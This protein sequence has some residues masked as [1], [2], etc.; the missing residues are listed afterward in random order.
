MPDSHVNAAT[1]LATL[2]PLPGIFV[3]DTGGI[4]GLGA[5]LLAGGG[6]L[7]GLY[8]PTA[9]RVEVV[10]KSDRWQQ[11][12]HELKLCSGYFGLPNL[13]L[14][15]VPDA[16][17]GDEYKFFVQ[18]GV[19]Q[20]E[21]WVE[22]PYA[23]ELG[24][25]FEDNNC[26]VVDPTGFHWTDAG[27]R[28]PDRADLILYELSV[29][30]FTEGD[31]DIQEDRRGKFAG[32]AERVEEGYFERLGVTALS[33][34]PLAEFPDPQGPGTLG[35]SPSLYCTVERD[36]GTPDD[37]R[38][39]V[40]TAHGHGLAVILDQV[41]N[42][43]SND[44]N[45]LWQL[46]L[47][48]PDEE[49][50]DGE[51]GLYFNG[52]TPWGNRIA[53][54]RED[55]Q[56]LLIDA[57]KLLIA[58]YHVDGFRFDATHTDYM[59]HGFLGRL[60]RELTAF[61]PEVILIA[62][63]LPN[64]SDLNRSGFDGFAQW[65]DPYHDKMKALLREGTYQEFN[66]YDTDRLADIFYFSR[67]IYAA[68]TNNVVN[69]TE[70]HD[71]TSVP[72]EVG[73][74][75]AL[76]HPAA[77]D[78][79]GRLGLFATMVALGQPMIYMGHEF[80]VERDRNI[81]SFAWPTDGPS[82]NGF[83]RWA[84]RLIP[85]R[86]RYPALRISGSDPAG[87]GRF[88][89]IL[90]PWMDQRHGGGKKV[91]GWR[92]RPTANAFDTM[93]VLLSFENHPVTVDLELGLAGTWVKLADVESANDVPPEGTNSAGDPTALHSSDGRFGGFELPGSSGF[94]YK[95]EE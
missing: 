23:R 71:E 6:V 1:F 74:N 3:P 95:W 38:N 58:E 52:T 80:N 45:P 24:P 47:E 66:H 9:A 61:K 90:G 53:T 46:I 55:V 21:R 31:P 44:F 20:G 18:G 8:H 28:T 63:N 67:S 48:H 49:L 39:L 51:G 17:A 32:V 79:K 70:S 75:P 14:G 65:A 62:E 7:F 27:W 84:S 29:L 12:R 91:L 85:L 72:F 26:V 33:L 81:V 2:S 77:K 15:V 35:Y 40:N 69:Y 13:W 93:V 36:F 16:A 73:T 89:W 43:T 5:T 68:H 4:S 37:L 88:S 92:L 82:S 57:C 42:H 10:D 86:R 87:D 76:N 50:R 41:F 60:A 25:S 19:P 94:L 54:E 11:P 34:M 30:G 22:D 59:D 83:Y 64:Q 56:N 78:R